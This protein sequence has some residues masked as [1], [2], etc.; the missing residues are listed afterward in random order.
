[1][2]RRFRMIFIRSCNL[3]FTVSRA[4]CTQ[5]NPIKN[6]P[7]KATKSSE[8]LPSKSYESQQH[9]KCY[10]ISKKQICLTVSN[11]L[12]RDYRKVS[13]ILTQ[14]NNSHQS[15]GKC[16]QIGWNSI[17]KCFFFGEEDESKQLNNEY[18]VV[19]FKGLFLT[20]LFHHSHTA[21]A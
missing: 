4:E 19:E 18:V 1:M 15:M 13:I 2:F 8:V 5:L 6:G 16:E 12:L 9:S 17:M 3:Q 20:E 14:R 21:T 7:Y 11:Y 10:D